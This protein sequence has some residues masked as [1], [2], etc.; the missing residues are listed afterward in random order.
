MTQPH[1]ILKMK[2]DVSY[3][4]SIKR[5]RET[6][7]SKKQGRI[8]IIAFGICVLIGLAIYFSITTQ[9]K[10]ASITREDFNI[11]K[12]DTFDFEGEEIVQDKDID[13][14]AE[15][16]FLLEENE[17]TSGYIH[18]TEKNIRLGDDAEE[19]ERTYRGA[20]T[21]TEKE[22][23]A[24]KEKWA[25]YTIKQGEYVL[26]IRVLFEGDADLGYAPKNGY[27]QQIGWFTKEAYDTLASDSIW[28]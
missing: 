16:M 26:C 19:V 15:G 2:R 27:V 11:Y 1:A 5:K 4:K 14:L 17:I 3:I 22:N 23:E 24:Q 10:K 21:K 25:L 28:K 7:M 20:Y 9:Y 6:D 18:L 12:T 8:L 13:T